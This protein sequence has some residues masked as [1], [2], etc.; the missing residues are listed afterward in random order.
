MSVC[1]H[2]SCQ[3]LSVNNCLLCTTDRPQE[4]EQTGACVEGITERLPVSKQSLHFEGRVGEPRQ[5]PVL[6]ARRFAAHADLAHLIRLANVRR[7]FHLHHHDHTYHTETSINIIIMTALIQFEKAGIW[8]EKGCH[9]SFCNDKVQ[10]NL[11]W[12]EKFKIDGFIKGN[13]LGTPKTNSALCGYTGKSNSNS[14]NCHCNYNVNYLIINFQDCVIISVYTMR[15]VND[16]TIVW[17]G[18][19]YYCYEFC[20]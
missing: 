11:S 5:A 2:D 6:A 16:L 15:Q 3:H 12:R 13:L 19:Y 4:A 18:I 10:K 17:Q 8:E 14:P 20:K 1:G 7:P 9:W